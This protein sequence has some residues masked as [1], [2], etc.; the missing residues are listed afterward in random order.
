MIY[1][2][3]GKH[4][5]ENLLIEINDF[6][7]LTFANFITFL[8]IFCFDFVCLLYTSQSSIY[9]IRQ[10]NWNDTDI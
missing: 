8:T 7:G 4:K 9:F 3:E 6:D 10:G 2:V 5:E 1:F